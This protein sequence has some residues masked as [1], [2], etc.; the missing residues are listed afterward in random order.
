M[1]TFVSSSRGL[2]S[3]EKKR[4]ETERERERRQYVDVKYVFAR[5]T[6]CV[7]MVSLYE[8]EERSK[9]AQWQ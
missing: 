8:N 4:R 2:L 6:R 9:G 1:F 3:K 7:L 5:R